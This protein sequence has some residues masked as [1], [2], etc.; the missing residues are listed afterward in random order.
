MNKSTDYTVATQKVSDAV[1]TDNF[2]KYFKVALS[3]CSSVTGLQAC[4]RACV[5]ACVCVCVVNMNMLI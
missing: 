4:V 5:R 1:S 3:A 2:V